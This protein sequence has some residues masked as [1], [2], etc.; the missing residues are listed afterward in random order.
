MMKRPDTLSLGITNPWLLALLVLVLT[1]CAAGEST[2]RQRNDRLPAGT[3][4][5][6]GT[7][8]DVSGQPGGGFREKR[9]RAAIMQSLTQTDLLVSQPSPHVVTL[10]AEITDFTGS[11]LPGGTDIRHLK[12]R[13]YLQDMQGNRIGSIAA[14][15]AVRPGST[16][17]MGMGEGVFDQIG[18]DIASDIRAH[19]DTIQ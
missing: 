11:A 5:R 12:V 14:E 19:M 13:A 15:R 1:G 6:M 18:T 2:L 9:L 3:R 10:T 7:V 17:P 4:I 8:S 16:L